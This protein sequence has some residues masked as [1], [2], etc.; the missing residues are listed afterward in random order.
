VPLPQEGAQKV[1]V[2]SVSAAW[3]DFNRDAIVKALGEH[4]GVDVVVWRVDA[5]MLALELG[6]DSRGKKQRN[7]GDD[8]ESSG[9]F[10]DESE[11]EETGEDEGEVVAAPAPAATVGLCTL[12]SS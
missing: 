2:A 3:A 1:A 12:E 11:S 10:G 8:E 6:T 9:G 7:G 4:A 5:R